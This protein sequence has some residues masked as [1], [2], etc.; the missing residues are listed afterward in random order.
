M[1]ETTEHALSTKTWDGAASPGAAGFVRRFEADWGRSRRS[2]RPDPV[3]YLPAGVA[4]RPAVLLALLRAEIG[5]RWEAGGPGPRRVVPRPLPRPG[6]RLG[7]RPD[8]TRNSASARSRARPRPRTS[9]S[10]GSPPCRVGSDGCSTST[11]WSDRGARRRSRGRRPRTCRSRSRVRRSP[12]SGCSTSWAG[13]RSPGSSWPR[14]GSSP[15]GRSR[16]RC[17]GPARGSRRRWRGSSTPTSCRS[18]RP[19]P[20]RR[21]GSTCSACPT[22]AG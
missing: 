3:D 11:T 20:T 21:R 1:A 18:T 19:G 15:T 14:S 10:S 4:D 17:R 7:R 12:G 22:S 5:L 8:L 9:T 16:S 6:P 2:S 13:G